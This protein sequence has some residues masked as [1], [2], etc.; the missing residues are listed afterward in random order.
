LESLSL[1]YDHQYSPGFVIAETLA[2][3]LQQNHARWTD[4]AER[5]VNALTALA[6]ELQR[7]NAPRH[8]IRKEVSDRAN[9]SQGAASYL[10]QLLDPGSRQREVLSRRI[11]IPVDRL[12]DDFC[13][14]LASS[15]S[16]QCDRGVGKVHIV[17]MLGELLLEWPNAPQDGVVERLIA[18]TKQTAMVGDKPKALAYLDALAACQRL[19]SHRLG[20]ESGLGRQLSER[21][22]RAALEAPNN[23][24]YHP[25]RDIHNKLVALIDMGITPEHSAFPRELCDEYLR[26]TAQATA[27]DQRLALERYQRILERLRT[28]GLSLEQAGV[29]QFM[30]ALR[31]RLTTRYDLLAISVS[32]VDRLLR[33]QQA[34]GRS[35]DANT[36]DRALAQWTAKVVAR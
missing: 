1:S 3:G 29:E 18:A 16:V 35:L 4:F 33:D 31:Q 5:Y 15:D 13:D 19:A 32:E 21:L 11:G 9:M 12:I 30:H 14:G 10:V 22:Y 36:I 8:A 23:R 34:Q 27:D 25:A 28:A 20:I 24:V 17:D 7:N 6:A 26:G 2:R